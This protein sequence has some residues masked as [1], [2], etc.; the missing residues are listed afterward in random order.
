M[1][2]TFTKF[3]YFLFYSSSL[4]M[5]DSVLSFYGKCSSVCFV[6][7]SYSVNKDE[8][9]TKWAACVKLEMKRR[10]RSLLQPCALISVSLSHL[11]APK[12]LVSTTLSLSPQVHKDCCSSETHINHNLAYLD[13]FLHVCFHCRFSLLLFR[14]LVSLCFVG[15]ETVVSLSEPKKRSETQSERVS[16]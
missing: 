10:R 13:Y 5:F 14:V 8:L 11:V 2:T 7:G 15:R 3:E 1:K 9:P 6:H 16:K 12:L 4:L